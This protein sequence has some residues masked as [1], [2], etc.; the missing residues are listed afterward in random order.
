MYFIFSIVC[1]YPYIVIC[2]YDLLIM[3]TYFDFVCCRVTMQGNA[4]RVVVARWRPDVKVQNK[5]EKFNSRQSS[6]CASGAN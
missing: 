5:P 1:V 6:Y 4:A 3:F 2:P